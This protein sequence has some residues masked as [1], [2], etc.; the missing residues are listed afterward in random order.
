MHNCY[1]HA[2]SNDHFFRILCKYGYHSY[3]TNISKYYQELQGR[4]EF[5]TV[6]KTN[7]KNYK[8]SRP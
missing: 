4:F 6:P 5:E 7:L 3:K 2:N 1:G 8:I